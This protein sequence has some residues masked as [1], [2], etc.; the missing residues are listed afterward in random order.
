MSKIRCL[1]PLVKELVVAAAVLICGTQAVAQ[2]RPVHRLYNINMPPGA[3]GAQQL[4]S[5]YPF[6]GYVQPVKIRVPEGADV[7]IAGSEAFEITAPALRV[8]LMVGHVYRLK[9]SNIPRF[10][11]EEIYPSLEIIN[12]LYPPRGMKDRFPIPIEIAQEDLEAAIAGRMVVRVVYVE[13]PNEAFPKQEDP[14]YQRYFDVL[15][16]EDPLHVADELGRPIA[17]LRL[18]SRRPNYTGPDREFL[19]RSP[20]F[21]LTP[22]IVEPAGETEDDS[23]ASSS[24]P[25]H[26]DGGKVKEIPTTE[27]ASDGNEESSG[28]EDPFADDNIKN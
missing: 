20:P 6:Q 4:R 25:D 21:H 7:A 16:E 1:N 5:N 24:N 28:V 12:R 15:P 23:E 18:G 17:I 26:I 8:G 19:F 10:E 22:E 14:D 9:V 2:E 11:G 27:D 13:D 3:I